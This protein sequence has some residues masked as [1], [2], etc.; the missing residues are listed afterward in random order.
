GGDHA[1]H[2]MAGDD[3]LAKLEPLQH[4]E[5][6]QGD[7]EHVAQTFLALRPTVARQQGGDDAVPG[8]QSREKRIVWPET[9]CY[10]EG[11]QVFALACL[12]HLD[13]SRRR[14][15]RQEGHSAAIRVGTGSCMGWHQK[16]S[17]WLFQSGHRLR[18]CG[19]TFSANSLVE[20]RTL[21]SG[22][23]PIWN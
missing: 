1:A 18:R 8:C 22:M 4:V 9:A 5:H 13:A 14:V 20:W 11:E 10:L 23:L 15:Q 21:S 12:D 16:R 7:V 2:G 6:M 17:S 3:R 19:M